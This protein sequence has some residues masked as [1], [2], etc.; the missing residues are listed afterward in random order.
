MEKNRTNSEFL[1]VLQ[2][3]KRTRHLPWLE[4]AIAEGIKI[5]ARVIGGGWGRE[6]N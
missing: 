5:L 4:P 6:G 1:V 2:R 3:E